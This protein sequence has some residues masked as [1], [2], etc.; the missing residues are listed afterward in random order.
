M[1]I[2][3]RR[4]RTRIVYMHKLES[5]FR[6]LQQKHL[7][8]GGL[9]SKH[10]LLTV[11]GAGSP[12]SRWRDSHRAYTAS[13]EGPGLP[14]TAVFCCALAWRREGPKELSAVPSTNGSDPTG[15]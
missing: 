3:I 4:G 10:L 13:A 8:L 6:L 11:L 5:S 15:L 1:K 2:V 9:N 14:Q 7:R 12:R